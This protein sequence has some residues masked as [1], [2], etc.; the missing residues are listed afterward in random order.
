MMKF[1]KIIMFILIVN[2]LNLYCQNTVDIDFFLNNIGN[3]YSYKINANDYKIKKI[4]NGLFRK[5]LLPKVTLTSSIPYQR[6]IS[7]VTQPDGTI[8]FIERNYLNPNI[9]LNTTQFL[10]FTGGTISLSNSINY[11]RDFNNNYTNFSSNW[12]NLSYQQSINGYNDYKWEKKINTLTKKK[13]SIEYYKNVIRL[14]YDIA[15][16]YIDAETSQLK[17]HLLQENMNKVKFMLNEINE[18]Y[19]HGRAIKTDVEQTEL[20]LEQLKGYLEANKIERQ[21]SLSQLKRTAN[22]E[23]Q[24]SILLEGVEEIEFTINK[25]ELIKI[26]EENGYNIEW[27]I[28]ELEAEANLDRIKK[29]GSMSLNLQL[30][31]GLNSSANEISQ[32]FNTPRQTQFVTLG[33]KVPILDWGASKDKT[34]IAFVEKENLKYK[35]EEERNRKIQ[36]IEELINYYWTLKSQIQSLKQQIILSNKLTDNYKELLSLGRKTVSEYRNQI[37]ENINLSIECEKLKNNL[38]LL[39]L[40]I[41]EL[42]LKY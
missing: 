5:S 14:K 7:D 11:S 26:M 39:K 24:D 2:T 30:G 38:Y 27:K 25:E 42:N 1:R 17:S 32:L 12:V 13:D 40:K 34:N 8:K 15:K 20:T 22:I 16:S 37:Y 10:P 6:A 41:D 28:K 36:A 9:G 35:I 23:I 29:E 33:V 21:N 18:K 31:L 4:Q 19:K 3:S